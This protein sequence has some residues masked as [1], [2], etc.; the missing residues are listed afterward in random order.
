MEISGLSYFNA[1]F[2]YT[3]NNTN[4]DKD[5]TAVFPKVTGMAAKTEAATGKTTNA[6]AIDLYQASKASASYPTFADVLSL[7]DK[8]EI[9]D[10]YQKELEDA[11]VNDPEKYQSMILES[12]EAAAK[13]F[14]QVL[15]I[16]GRNGGTATHNGVSIGFDS[17]R[18]QMNI[19]DTSNKG[20][21]IS[22]NLSNGWVLNFNRDNIDDVSKIL[23]LFSPED[24][25]RI[26]EA[27]T[28]D[29]MA[30]SMEKEIDDT[31]ASVANVTAD[32][33]VQSRQIS[34][35]SITENPVNADVLS[36]ADTEQTGS[37]TSAAESAS[38]KSASGGSDENDEESEVKTEIVTNPD[39]S[40]KLVITTKIGDTETVT[41]IKLAP[42]AEENKLLKNQSFG[43]EGSKVEQ[44]SDNTEEI[45]RTSGLQQATAFQR[46]TEFQSMHALNAYEANFMYAS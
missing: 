37:N 42:A 21:V 36:T 26:M 41:N 9:A 43:D 12:E 22:V 1:Y 11:K 28:T 19:G 16:A 35:D 46:P 13:S 5:N 15:E 30:K 20:N 3:S 17:E 2:Q 34:V 8:T 24:V 39:G 4:S 7:Q 10:A 31:E 29:N 6:N 44:V 33:A 38:D 18:H 45:E 32:T 14:S 25:R 40:R 23:D 27:I